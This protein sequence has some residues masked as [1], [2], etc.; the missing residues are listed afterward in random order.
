MKYLLILLTILL[1]SCDLYVYPYVDTTGVVIDTTRTPTSVPPADTDVYGQPMIN[2]Y[3]RAWIRVQTATYSDGRINIRYWLEVA[4]ASVYTM[5]ASGTT[6][7]IYSDTN[8][9]KLPFEGYVRLMDAKY[10]VRLYLDPVHGIVLQ[11][12]SRSREGYE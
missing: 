9:T 10:R 1:C 6:H 7:E 3:K 4:T 2:P 8:S 12:L 5:Y 11:Y